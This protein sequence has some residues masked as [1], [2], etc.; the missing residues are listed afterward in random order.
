[1]S[2]RLWRVGLF[3]MFLGLCLLHNCVAYGQSGR[4]LAGRVVDQT[5]A[6]IPRATLTLY[7]DDRVRTITANDLG[8]FDFSVLPPNSHTL[9]ASSPGFKSARMPITD[10]TPERVSVRL[11][12]GEGSTI[13]V[14][15]QLASVS[16]IYNARM[17]PVPSF[18]EMRPDKTHLSGTVIDPWGRPLA[19]TV[20][21]LLQEDTVAPVVHHEEVKIGNSIDVVPSFKQTLVLHCDFRQRWRLSIRVSIRR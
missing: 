19:G 6:G 4:N 16:E 7:S 18:Y 2:V 13:V 9:D 11:E 17:L 5:G 20:L 15:E 14:C 3:G 1:M 21:L 12:I 10:K 8:E